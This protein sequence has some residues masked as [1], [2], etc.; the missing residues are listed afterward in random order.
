MTTLL[1]IGIILVGYVLPA[2]LTYRYIRLLYSKDGRL[3]GIEPSMIDM[4]VT[5]TPVINI[6]VLVMWITLYPKERTEKPKI[7]Y[8]K[9]FKVK[10]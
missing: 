2:Y 1:I 10:K 4:V 5:L 9:F 3:S 8:M 7:D 6:L